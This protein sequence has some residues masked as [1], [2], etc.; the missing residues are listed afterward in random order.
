MPEPSL[1]HND[2][3]LL[4]VKEAARAVGVSER[5]VWRWIGRGLVRRH[6]LNGRIHVAERELL[7]AEH[8]TRR[9]P[10]GRPRADLCNDPP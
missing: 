9:E 1:R 3:A 6:R 8:Q 4:T 5:A 7:I 10:K 2:L